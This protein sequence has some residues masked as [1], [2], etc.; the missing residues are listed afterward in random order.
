MVQYILILGQQIICNP[1]SLGVSEV[2]ERMNEWAQ[3]SAWAKQAVQS[4]QMSK[5]C[6]RTDKQSG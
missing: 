3:Q 2:S 1:M 6:E 5:Q 4:K